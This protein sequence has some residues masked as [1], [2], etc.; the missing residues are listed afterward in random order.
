MSP[1]NSDLRIAGRGAFYPGA[2]PDE[3]CPYGP[4]DARRRPWLNGWFAEQK[5]MQAMLDADRRLD[6]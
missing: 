3:H 2:D 1:S 4:R 5:Y 6:S